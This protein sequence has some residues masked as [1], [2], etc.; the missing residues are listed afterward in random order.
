MSRGRDEKKNFISV[1]LC[2]QR[3]VQ[4]IRDKSGSPYPLSVNMDDLDLCADRGAVQP[5]AVDFYLYSGETELGLF[6]V[7]QDGGRHGNLGILLCES[8]T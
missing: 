6:Y 2:L 3:Y 7:D 1:V 5:D 4:R 8:F